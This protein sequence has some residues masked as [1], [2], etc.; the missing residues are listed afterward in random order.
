MQRLL[1]EFSEL[2]LVKKQLRFSSMIFLGGSGKVTVQLISDRSSV[3]S[4]CGSVVGKN[5]NKQQD[6]F[7]LKII[8]NLSL[9]IPFLSENGVWQV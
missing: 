6:S 1:N 9:K 2:F 5:L 4:C 3:K 8:L 7:G